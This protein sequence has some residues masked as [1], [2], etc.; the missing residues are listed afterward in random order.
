M[1][2][3]PSVNP[4]SSRFSPFTDA[5][6]NRRRRVAGIGATI[7]II[8]GGVGIST[9]AFQGASNPGGADSPEEAVREF[10]EAL[11]REDVLGMIDVTVPEEVTALRAVF[12]DATKEVER[13]GILDESFSLE[14]VAGID[15]AVPGL[16]ADDREPRHRPRSRHGHRRH[17]GRDVRSGVVPTR[18]DRPRRG[19]RRAGGQPAVASAGR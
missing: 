8:A 16:D 13:V 11:E 4:T 19:G 15:V 7:A 2:P 14:A 12:D 6:P 17:A 9:V 3:P 5:A 10:S 18:F 1:H